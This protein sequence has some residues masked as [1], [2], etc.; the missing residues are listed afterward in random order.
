MKKTIKIPANGAMQAVAVCLFI[1]GGIA[2]FCFWPLILISPFAIFALNKMGA[3]RT[4]KVTEEI[5]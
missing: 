2:T 1:I 3:A 4:I 5:E